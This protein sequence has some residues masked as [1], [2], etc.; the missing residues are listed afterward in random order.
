MVLHSSQP[1]HQQKTSFFNN[2]DGLLCPYTF[3]TTN[4]SWHEF[5]LY[6]STKFFQFDIWDASLQMKT[7]TTEADNYVT[8]LGNSMRAC[9]VKCKQ[10]H[11]LLFPSWFPASTPAKRARSLVV[12]PSFPL[13]GMDTPRL[14][15]EITADFPRLDVPFLREEQDK[16]L[17][18]LFCGAERRREG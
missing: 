16:A 13:L 2:Y 5:K 7:T 11:V 6:Y 12:L 10:M 3:I 17:Q 9:V 1:Q 14:L 8:R 4:P 15:R 18:P